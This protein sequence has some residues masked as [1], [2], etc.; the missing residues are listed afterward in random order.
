MLSTL[1][2]PPAAENALG[3]AV[4]LVD[5]T[6]GAATRP[7]WRTKFLNIVFLEKQKNKKQI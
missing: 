1:E 3:A 5:L 7:A 6:A 2:P 4:G